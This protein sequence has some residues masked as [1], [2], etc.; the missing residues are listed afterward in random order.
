MNPAP[1]S[2]PNRQLLVAA[3]SGR[4]STPARDLCT[5][6][7]LYT[8]ETKLNQSPPIIGDQ[9]GTLIAGARNLV[10]TNKIP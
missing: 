1:T 7:K 8:T 6:K 3:G 10:Q 9:G 2:G 5:F 4:P